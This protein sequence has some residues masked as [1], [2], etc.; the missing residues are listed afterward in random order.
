MAPLRAAEYGVPIFR[1]ASSGVSQAVDYDGGVVAE[2][3]MPGN[4]STLAAEL[5]PHRHGLPADRVFAPVCTAISA[6]VLASLLFL[7]WRRL[8]TPS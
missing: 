8:P 3:P 5:H 4:G 7:A 1:L 6:L 2:A